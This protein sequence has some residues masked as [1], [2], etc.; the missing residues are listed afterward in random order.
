MLTLA[1]IAAGIVLFTLRKPLTWLLIAIVA[2]LV[3][4]IFVF[5]RSIHRLVLRAPRTIGVIAGLI[6][7]A[8]IMWATT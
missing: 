6:V 4:G 1:L 8:F 2:A 7:S 5:F 3:A